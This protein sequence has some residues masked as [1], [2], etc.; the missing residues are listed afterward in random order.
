M[1][2]EKSQSVLSY[3]QISVVSRITQFLRLDIP[4]LVA[5]LMLSVI[6]LVILYSA[7]GQ[8]MNIINR[9]LIRL[10]VAFFVMLVF[11]HIPPSVLLNWSLVFFTAGLAM[12][13]AVLLFGDIGKGAQRWLDLQFIK[14]QPSELMKIAVPMMVA[15][16]IVDKPLPPTLPRLLIALV[17]VTAPTFLIIRQP[18]LGTAL[19][20][21]GAGL[22]VL[23][24]AGLRWRLIAGAGAMIAVAAPILWSNMHSYQR[25]RVMTFLNPEH[26][27][28]G[29]GYHII[30]SKIA[31]GSGGLFGKG[32]LNGTQSNLDFLPERHTDF[33][34]AV[35]GE[36]FG[37]AGGLALLGLYAFIT[38]RGLYLASTSQDCYGRLLAGSMII[39][40]LIYLFVNIGMVVGLL[41]VVG[42]PLPLIS[43]GGT[44]LVT[45]MIGFGVI[46]SANSHRRLLS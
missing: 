41:P 2:M 8:D 21:A 32:W 24:L 12:L 9:Q 27:P 28:L 29:S 31:V 46:M 15:R 10:L 4:L 14:F 3:P 19:L 18:D 1:E 5:L 44:S 39:T 25:Q 30:Q 11:A 13:V 35:F 36:E 22:V 17:I 38:V 33:I 43:Y 20:V 42:V 37:F 6:G 45:I 40:F 16:F 23:F 26:D 7:S 34:F